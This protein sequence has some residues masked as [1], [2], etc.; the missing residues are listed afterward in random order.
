MNYL[1]D[2]NVV[3]EW[4]KSRPDAGVV[5]W[6]TGVDEDRAFLSVVTSAEIRQGI[7]RM[8]DAARR[9]RLAAW[10]VGQ[11][12]PRFEGRV[13]AIDAAVADGWGRLMA[14]AQASGRPVGVMDCFL[15]ATA[16]A[17]DL[18]LVTRNTSD[19]EPFNLRIVN[20]WTG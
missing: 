2:T 11:L 18:T 19:F 7:E 9:N 3:S 16:D 6:L 8:P 4:A 14:R 15:A 13:L 20:P 17:F 1:L 5:D 12:L 10:L